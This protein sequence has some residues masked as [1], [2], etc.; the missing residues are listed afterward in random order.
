MDSSCE[1]GVIKAKF[2]SNGWNRK[3]RKAKRDFDEAVTKLL[4]DMC[5]TIHD[6]V[7]T[8]TPVWEGRALA[9]FQWT[10]G[11]PFTGE[12]DPIDTGPTG[13]T[14]QMALGSEP[15][16]D[17]NS[18]LSDQ[19]LALID[20]NRHDVPIFLSN[21]VSYFAELEYGRAPTPDTSR[22]PPVGIL[23]AATAAVRQKFSYSATG[24]LKITVKD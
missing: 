24:V 15:R 9:N 1:T 23:R 2:D 6:I 22:T 18:Y 14:S 13:R 12:I 10:Q 7:H 16:R 5:Y 4:K 19:S 17:A 8:N 21:N 11:A 20:F 3:T